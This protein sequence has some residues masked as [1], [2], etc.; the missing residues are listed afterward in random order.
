MRNIQWTTG[1]P[2]DL[3]PITDVTEILP[4]HK[5]KHYDT[6]RPQDIIAVIVHHTVTTA[7]IV[8]MAK[9]HVNNDGWAGIGYHLMIERDRLVQVNDL[10]SHSNHAKGWNDKAI[11]ISIVGDLTQRPMTDIERM[12]LYGAILTVKKLYP[13]ITRV[14]GHNEASKELDLPGTA[15]PGTD[16]NR[17]RQD[18]LNLENQMAYQSSPDSIRTQAY[19]VANHTRYLYNMANGKDEHGNPATPQ[20]QEWAVKKLMELFPAFVN[21]GLLKR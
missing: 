19:A 14:L 12:L 5:D 6:R 10:N 20:Q 18:I 13:T 9:S 1:L 17:I 11:G 8:N 3:P 16:M 7:P 4:R 2:F 21:A 15:C